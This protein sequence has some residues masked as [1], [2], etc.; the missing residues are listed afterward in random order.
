MGWTQVSRAAAGTVQAGI[1]MVVGLLPPAGKKKSEAQKRRQARQAAMW[2][3]KEK[4]VG[5][6][7]PFWGVA[8]EVS[9]DGRSP[10][11][12]RAIQASRAVAGAMA[13]V[14]HVK[15]AAA[16]VVAGDGPANAGGDGQL[17]SWVF[18]PGVQ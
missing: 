17:Q 11:A 12:A 10:L 1:R 14:V 4:A 5:D 6:A 9:Q 15:R 16:E 18:D 8:I 3:N 2:A 13:R 7:A